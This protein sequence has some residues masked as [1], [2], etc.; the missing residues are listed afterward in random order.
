[1][2]KIVAI[3]PARMAS[4]RFPG[5]PLA[6]ICGLSMIEHVRRRVLLCKQLSNV[7]V[8]T[9]D[10][11]IKELVEKSGGL[12]IMTSDKHQMC[13]DR[14]A[15]AAKSLD[16]DIIINVQ[17]DEPL[18][19]PDIFQRTLEPIL[20][21]DA[22]KCVNLISPI[23]SDKEFNSLNAVKTVLDLKKNILFF[24]REPIPS[25]KKYNGKYERY[26]QVGMIVFTKDLLVKF[27]KMKRTPLEI[28]ESVDMLRLIENGYSVKAVIANES[29]YG[30][31]V[32]ED[33]EIVKELMK[34]DPLYKKYI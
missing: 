3:I 15:E 18:I 12:A 34:K 29:S 20:K 11:E 2:K 16:A 4:T 19:N 32:P 25:K 8:A 31:D 24:S 5:K 7:Y 17:G 6:D 10:K 23:T 22:C 33:L 9:C 13:T 14:V 21:D 26:K 28:V 30:V 27:S 1:M